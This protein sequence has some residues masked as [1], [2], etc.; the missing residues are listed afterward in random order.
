MP[1]AKSNW[2]QWFLR[3]LFIKQSP[4]TTVSAAAVI[5]GVSVIWI[6]L[7][8]SAGGL[9]NLNPGI[10]LIPIVIAGFYFGPLAG[11]AAAATIGMAIGPWMPSGTEIPQPG[12]D[13][14]I[15]LF[16]Y[17]AVGGIV[18]YLSLRQHNISRKTIRRQ[19]K[20]LEKTPEII[21]RERIKALQ[22][23]SRG[24][25]HDL[26]NTLA[27]ILGFSELLQEPGVSGDVDKATRYAKAIKTAGVNASAVVKR[28]REFYQM[29]GSSAALM[30]VDLGRIVDESLAMTEARWRAQARADGAEIAIS[31]DC[32]SG[33]VVLG[34]D[35]ELR[36]V[37]TNLIFNAVDAMPEGGSLAF[38]CERTDAAI[39]LKLS[40]TGKGMNPETL[41]RCKEVYFTTKA[42]G[43]GL[44]V[45][46]VNSIMRYHGGKLDIVSELGEGTSVTLTFPVPQP[47]KIESAEPDSSLYETRPLRILVAEDDDLVRE[48][49]EEVLAADGHEVVAAREGDRAV[50]A[51]RED[52]N[53]FDVVICDAAM[54]RL[55]G[56]RV[57]A[58]IRE[59]RPGMPFILLS[60]FDFKAKARDDGGEAFTVL[61]TKPV[62]LNELRQAL[63]Q[64]CESR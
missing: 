47:E 42:H 59:I 24:V 63:W 1:D 48:M 35:A 54:P 25:V 12:A 36:G 26:N 3:T 23:M 62:T 41:R 7:I 51:F 38:E 14:T 16:S 8:V 17:A 32:P 46:L 45:P 56:Q 15:R 2:G 30:P 4:R 13:W 31:M 11:I 20:L 64:A 34:N 61:L 39:K 37:L 44:G 18:G 9:A 40:D 55:S 33:L 43:T 6:L 10:L 52:A 57:A 50:S 21:E 19:Q 28:L 53:R 58:D 5:V 29:E 49:L 60:G 27:P 22:Q